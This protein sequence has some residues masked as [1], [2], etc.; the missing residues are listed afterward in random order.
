M[1]YLT[2]LTDRLRNPALGNI[3][4]GREAADMIDIWH[5]KGVW[6]I[7]K[8]VSIGIGDAYRIGTSSSVYFGLLQMS[9]LGSV[10]IENLA[11]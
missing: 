6:D 11:A 2:D 8:V 10:A 9:C 7:Q 5:V 4:T 3:L 1:S